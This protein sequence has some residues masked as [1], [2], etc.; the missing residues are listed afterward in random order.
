[1]IGLGTGAAFGLL[2]RPLARRLDE[3]YYLLRSRFVIGS[4]L[5]FGGIGAGI[6]VGVDALI[7]RERVIYRRDG[8]PQTRVAPVVGPG[9]GGAVV[10]VTW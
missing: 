7:R 1:M 9:V 4:A 3:D 6:G 5:V 8:R 2:G 10:S